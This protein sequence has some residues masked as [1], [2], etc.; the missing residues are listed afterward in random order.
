MKWPGNR[1]KL[2]EVIRSGFDR[3][4]AGLDKAEVAEWILRSTMAA[5]RKRNRKIAGSKSGLRAQKTAANR[6]AKDQSRKVKKQLANHRIWSI[7]P[8]QLVRGRSPSEL[9]DQLDPDRQN[10]WKPLIA[11]RFKRVIPR[12]SVRDFNFLDEPINT[13]ATLKE[14]SRIEG[15]ELNAYLDFDDSY[16]MDIGAYLVFAEI[17]P[18]LSKVFRGGKM[19]QAVQKVLSA[20]QLDDELAIGLPGVSNHNDVWAFPV[21]HRRPRGTTRSASANLVPQAREKVADQLCE[22]VDDWLAVASAIQDGDEEKAFEWALSIDGKSLIARMS[23]EILDNAERHSIKGS[24]DGDWS[25]SAFMVR[26][27]NDHTSK[28]EL[29]CY[30]A[31]LSVGRSI[32]EAMEH[33][34]PHVLSTFSKYLRQYERKGQSRS[35]LLTVLAL[36]DAITSDENAQRAGRGGTGLQDFLEFV[37][38]LGAAYKPESDVR[39]TIVS[40]KSCIRLKNPNLVGTR[41]S[42]GR[43]VHWCNRQNNPGLPPDRN[44]AFDLPEHFAGTLVSVAFTLDPTLFVTEPEL[45]SD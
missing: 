32:A 45:K 23:G 43:R 15:S 31:F 7:P 27:F 20:V 24:Y 21:K 5:V 11:R 39:M 22:L 19:S 3:R 2:R 38:D 14:L 9:L 6:F 42:R 8:T 44:M 25:T 34:S 40:G 1:S 17:W 35:T 12:L 26:R 36:Q 28:H 16:C 41:D 10:S 37:G 13:I 30:L 4:N 29:R 18:Q 33:A